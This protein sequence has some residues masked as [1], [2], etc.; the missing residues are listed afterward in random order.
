M[1]SLVRKLD[2]QPD[3]ITDLQV[4]NILV[5]TDFSEC[6]HR[7]LTYA[8]NIAH[9]QRSRLT[10]LHIVPRRLASSQDPRRD[11]AVLAATGAMNKLHADLSSSRL[12]REVSCQLLVRRGKTWDVISRIMRLQETDLVVIGTR[13]KTGLEK[14]ILGS[15][16]EEIFRQVP[17]PVLTVGPSVPD[18]AVAEAPQHILFPTDGSHA[19][20]AAEPYAYQ[21]GRAPGAQLTLLDVVQTTFGPNSKSDNQERLNH[22]REYLQ[23]TG[24]YAAWRQG[25]NTPDVVA[26][27]GAT[28]ETILDV[29]QRTGADL[30]IMGISEKDNLPGKFEWNDVYRVV[31]SA[32]CPVLTVRGVFPDPYFKRIL[33][34]EPV[35]AGIEINKKK[36][37]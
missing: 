31:S 20:K 30:I 37:H 22:A 28:V 19:A 10:L 26:Q 6:S 23:A 35:R 34:M 24:L 29:A 14:L 8:I 5:L 12:L 16:A 17:C 1:D 9:A 3:P 27:M 32:L 18:R 21:L 11:E 4:K 33:E 2:M 25:G 7:A 36:R 13:G 15:F